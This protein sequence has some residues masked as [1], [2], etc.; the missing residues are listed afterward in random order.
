[1]STKMKTVMLT[2][3]LAIVSEQSR[4]KSL[5]DVLACSDIVEVRPRTFGK[6]TTLEKRF[7]QLHGRK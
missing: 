3:S 5:K 4:K 6:R 7:R 2:A 1:M